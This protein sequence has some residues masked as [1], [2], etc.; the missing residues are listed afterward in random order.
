MKPA[1][2]MLAAAAVVLGAAACAQNPPA[3][4]E[5]ISAYVTEA[6]R[7]ANSGIKVVFGTNNSGMAIAASQALERHKVIFWEPGSAA[8]EITGRGYQ[9]TF[10]TVP[11]GTDWANTLAAS[12]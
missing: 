7:L 6:E 5:S 12:S 4:K 11:P 10:R 9:Y 3:S 1:M 8:D 2:R